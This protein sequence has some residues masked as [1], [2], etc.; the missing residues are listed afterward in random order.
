VKGEQKL[1]LETNQSLSFKGIRGKVRCPPAKA[2]CLNR[3]KEVVI[4]MFRVEPSEG[5]RE[6]K[7]LVILRG[8]D[9]DLYPDLAL[10]FGGIPCEIKQRDNDNIV[11]KLGENTNSKIIGRR[12]PVT[13]RSES[14]QITTSIEDLYLVS[15]FST[16]GTAQIRPALL[17]LVAILFTALFL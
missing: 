13:G 6:G 8:R 7:N 10:S 14:K 16:S 17:L 11:C 9:F 3:K 12:V 5:P 4:N 2:A 15:E 1:C